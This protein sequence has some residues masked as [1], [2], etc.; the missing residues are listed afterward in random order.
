MWGN[1]DARSDFQKT[2][3]D[4]CIVHIGFCRGDLLNDNFDTLVIRLL[5]ESLLDMFD[6]PPW[7]L[8]NPSGSVDRFIEDLTKEVGPRFIVL[9]SIGAAFKCESL[10][11][12]QRIKLFIESRIF[13]PSQKLLDCTVLEGL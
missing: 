3:C 4:C 6:E 13:G 1:A 10:G 9:D 12:I 7:I 8:T 2:L 11:D 5:V